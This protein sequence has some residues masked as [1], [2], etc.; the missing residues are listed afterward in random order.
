MKQ[1]SY[2][3]SPS[4]IPHGDPQFVWGLSWAV[5]KSFWPVQH[6]EPLDR[7]PLPENRIKSSV[8]THT[9]QPELL[10]PPPDKPLLRSILT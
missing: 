1:K 7:A 10:H 5:G 3:S 9:R 4:L 8:T 2:F 6:E